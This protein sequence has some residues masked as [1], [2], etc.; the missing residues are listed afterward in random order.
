MNDHSARDLDLSVRG[1]TLRAR[2]RGPDDGPPVVLLHGW[3]DQSGSFDP[4]AALLAARGLRAIA[5]DLRGHGDSSWAGAGAYYHLV[6]YLG[7]LDGA[8]LALGLLAPGA[9]PVRLV[10]HSLG[11]TLA[12]LYCAAR[13]GRLLHAALLDGIPMRV[14]PVEV[15]HRLAD[16]LGDLQTPRVRKT[17]G[18]IEEA[19]GRLRA[20]S[21]ALRLE[22]S[23]HLARGGVSPDPLQGGALAWKWDPWLRGHSPLPVTEQ[24]L[25]P[26]Y[27]QV[28]TPLLLL[29]A[30]TT[31]LPEERDLRALL[32]GVQGP[33]EIATIEGTSH[34]LHLEEP[35]LVTEKLLT[36]WA[37][38]GSQS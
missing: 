11:A 34:H 29:R 12:L 36:A 18:S 5:L 25:G 28:R 8:L 3:L 6:E 38:L 15:P 2:V 7:D 31:W 9:P 16:W 32:A 33:L 23:L 35:E 19:A 37:A 21:A 30:G 14:S 27:E 26:L 24:L 1:L 13:P 10:G 22:A 4:L 17:V 20:R